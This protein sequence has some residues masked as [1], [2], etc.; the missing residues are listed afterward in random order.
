MDGIWGAYLPDEE[1]EPIKKSFERCASLLG[2]GLRNVP[3]LM[4]RTPAFDGNDFELHDSLMHGSI[5]PVT[6][7]P[8]QPPGQ[9][10]PFGPGGGE[11]SETVLSR[12]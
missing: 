7:P 8:G 11:L 2:S 1:V 12:G 10:Q 9:V 5:L 6:I 4:T 3:T